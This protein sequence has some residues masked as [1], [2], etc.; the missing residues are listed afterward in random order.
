MRGFFEELGRAF[1]EM[2]Q[3]KWG[4]MTPEQ[5]F[6]DLPETERKMVEGW[7][8]VFASLGSQFPELRLG[9]VATTKTPGVTLQ[10]VSSAPLG[11]E[12]Q[13][14]VS[15]VAD[16]KAQETLKI[17][18]W[19][20]ER[21][22]QAGDISYE[23]L[24]SYEEGLDFRIVIVGSEDLDS[25]LEK[26]R[27]RGHE[28][29][30]ILDL[31]PDWHRPFY[32]AEI[33]PEILGNIRKLYERDGILW[34][35]VLEQM[36]L[37]TQGLEE[38]AGDQ[39][40]AEAEGFKEI[41]EPLLSVNDFRIRLALGDKLMRGNPPVSDLEEQLLSELT[42]LTFIERELEEADS[43]QQKLETIL[44]YFPEQDPE[45]LLPAF[46]RTEG[47][48]LADQTNKRVQIMFWLQKLKEDPTGFAAIDL[49]LSI[50]E[51]RHPQDEAWLR[52]AREGVKRYKAL[53][54]AA[55]ERGLLEDK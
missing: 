43:R 22:D 33:T 7:R 47:E 31:W 5:Y 36:D 38:K 27:G 15:Q 9:V 6:P 34:Q 17:K 26:Q 4:G 50:Q 3:V 44:K 19:K 24:P 45:L 41:L 35:A 21:E 53:Y 1:D 37:E 54:R 32:P 39:K 51:N 11:S 48:Q 30:S 25:F 29:F 16:E 28:T 49:N 40:L 14:Q 52:G 55:V 46:E 13:K 23:I 42:G 8:D 12:R 10:V 18:Q 2:H 20:Y